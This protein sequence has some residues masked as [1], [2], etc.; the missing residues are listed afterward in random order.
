MSY[1]IVIPARMASE[2]L[3]GKPLARIGSAT[4]VECVWRRA[5]SASAASVVIATDSEEVLAAA[6]AFGA[7]AVLT[8]ERHPSGSDRIAECADLK[9][10][11]DEELIV[12]LQGDEPL[13]P[14]ACLDQVAGL[15]EEQIRRGLC[16]ACDLNDPGRCAECG[17]CTR[18]CPMSLDVHGMVRSGLVEHSECTLCGTCVDTCPKDVIR[19]AFSAGK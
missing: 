16:F 1:H 13:M 6:Q 10:W 7:D 12:N 9:G 18:A 11:R 8:S 2:R 15:L 19:Y 14:A 17:V 5:Q 3:P 4:L